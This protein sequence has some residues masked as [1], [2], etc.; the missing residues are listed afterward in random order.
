MGLKKAANFLF[1]LRILKYIKRA[2][3]F[4][5]KGPV[6]ES[7]AEHSFYVSLIGWI[8]AKLEE[9]NQDKVLRMCLVHDIAETR[10]GERN[11]INKFYTKVSDE[12]KIAKEMAEDVDSEIPA[13]VK[14]FWLGKEKEVQVAKDADV[15]A[16]MLTEKDC[17]DLGNTKAKKW[18]EASLKRLRTKSGKELG[19]ELIEADADRWW[20]ELVKKHIEKVEFLTPSP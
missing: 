10:G 16:Q 2:G 4:Y 18:L 6:E 14:E 3:L 5:L 8:L 12:S 9:V 13:L 1:E 15:L 11:L 19:K 20:M 17:L 7:V